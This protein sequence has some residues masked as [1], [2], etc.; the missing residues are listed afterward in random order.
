M[1][2]EQNIRYKMMYSPDY[3]NCKTD[4]VSYRSCAAL[5]PL[6]RAARWMRMDSFMTGPALGQ[7]AEIEL[8]ALDRLAW[9]SKSN[10]YLLCKHLPEPQ[11]YSA[12]CIV[13]AT[14]C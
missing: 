10:D 8:W 14:N 3:A 12:P 9:Q 11:I 7:S 2:L 1:V 5:R 4:E 13:I 6:V